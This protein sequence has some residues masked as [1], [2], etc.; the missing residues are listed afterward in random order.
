MKKSI[1]TYLKEYCQRLSD[2]NLKFISQRLTQRLFGDTAEL[3][4]FLSGT[5]ELDKW[6]SSAL[7]CQDLYEMLESFQLIVEKEDKNRE[8][9]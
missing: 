6:L 8:A 3:L 5:R 4:D 7:S 1:D 9:A 2:D